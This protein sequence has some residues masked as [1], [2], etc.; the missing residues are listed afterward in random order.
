MSHPFVRR[1]SL[2]LAAITA[3]TLLTACE[4]KRVKQLDTGI[5]RDSALSVM[6]HDLK[7][8]S[9]P[10]SLPNVYR[11]ARYLVNG[12]NL[13]VLFFTSNDEKVGKDSVPTRKLTPI[14]FLENKLI[15]R[16]WDFLDSLSKADKIDV[17]KR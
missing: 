13:E 6:S 2:I 4:D 12:K 15:G 11:R 5:T 14:V 1:N 3:A 16:G 17:V 7:P 8:G 9:G 10:D